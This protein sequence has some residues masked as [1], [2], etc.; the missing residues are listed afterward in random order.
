VFSYGP[1]I[2][3]VGF[4]RNR[5]CCILPVGA[6]D[7]KDRRPFVTVVTDSRHE[8]I[9]RILR[10]PTPFGAQSASWRSLGEFAART[11]DSKFDDRKN[12]AYSQL[13]LS[14][15][16]RLGNLAWQYINAHSTRRS[17]FTSQMTP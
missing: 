16:L 12:V 6:V 14:E 5:T 9:S 4:H 11:P 17:R 1:Q 10:N 2:R 7:L 8:K 3:A 15:E 13:C